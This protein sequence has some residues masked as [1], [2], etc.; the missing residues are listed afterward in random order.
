[1]S[2]ESESLMAIGAALCC[3]S[4]L[5]PPITIGGIVLAMKR[6]TSKENASSLPS[7]VVP[8]TRPLNPMRADPSKYLFDVSIIH[9]LKSDLNKFRLALH[10]HKY[11]LMDWDFS[12]PRS[13]LMY[14][15]D[16]IELIRLY[17]ISEEGMNLMFGEK[18]F[19]EAQMSFY[20]Y[21]LQKM[22]L[23][24]LEAQ[25]RRGDL[26]AYDEW[27]RIMDSLKDKK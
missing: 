27:K 4:F 7:P 8:D 2:I 16:M 13:P 22:Q 15:G 3:S 11:L 24:H 23:S 20:Q 17:L 18:D 25:A 12:D 10:P 21:E 9:G 5:V 19:L 26:I 1:M 6:A 14:H